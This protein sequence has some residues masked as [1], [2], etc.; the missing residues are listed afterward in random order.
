MKE[1]DNIAYLDLQKTGSTVIQNVLR[2]VLAEKYL[3]RK[4]HSTLAEKLNRSKVYF[5]SVREPL[6]LYISLFNFGAGTAV[7]HCLRL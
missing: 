4:P 3:W 2:N 6:S 1:Y 5:I 7:E